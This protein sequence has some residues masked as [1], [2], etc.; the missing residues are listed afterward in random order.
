M[1]LSYNFER[2]KALVKWIISIE[3]D[4]QYE[5]EQFEQQI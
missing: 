5:T 4:I 3:F 1:I 2:F